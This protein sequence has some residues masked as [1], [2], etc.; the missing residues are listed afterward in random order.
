M[1]IFGDVKLVYG[2]DAIELPNGTREPLKEGYVFDQ[3]LTLL[4]Y[5]LT[6]EK[7]WE[8]FNS[9]RNDELYAEYVE[10][11]RDIFKKHS[12]E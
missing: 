6:A 8:W 11:A 5:G 3:E 1:H 4:Y 7:G 9:V 10:R 2:E 12:N